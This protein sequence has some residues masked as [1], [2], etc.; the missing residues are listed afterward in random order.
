MA[1]RLVAAC[2]LL[3]TTATAFVAPVVPTPVTAVRGAPVDETVIGVQA[4]VG[5]WD[6]LGY[7]TTQPEA[8]ERR[9]AVRVPRMSDTSREQKLLSCC[10][11]RH[12]LSATL[13]RSPDV[14]DRS[15]LSDPGAGRAQ[16]RA[17]RDDGRRRCVGAP[18]E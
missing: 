10:V 3:A 17:H 2:A 4:P 7:S 18:P 15:M 12:T 14:M 8:F 16:A 13:G 5:F 6:P 1:A 9:R 11:V